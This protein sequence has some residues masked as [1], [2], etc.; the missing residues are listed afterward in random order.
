[1]VGWLPPYCGLLAIGVEL[2]PAP[3]QLVGLVDVA[4]PF[5]PFLP[6][7]Q[8]PDEFGVPPQ[9]FGRVGGKLA[10]HRPYGSRCSSIETMGFDPEAAQ[11]PGGVLR[12]SRWSPR[13]SAP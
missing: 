1:M 8:I 2:L 3:L 9:K 13:P 4:E 10:G 5:R 6:P 12:R 7:P 11:A